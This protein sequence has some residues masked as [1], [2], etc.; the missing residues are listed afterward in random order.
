MALGRGDATEAVMHFQSALA[1]PQN[2]GEAKHLLA[3]QNDI[4]YWL[5]V[6][7]EHQGSASSAQ[8]WWRSAAIHQGDF[9]QMSVRAVSDMTYWSALAEQKLGNESAATALLQQIYQYS[10]DMEAGEP[11]IDYFA[12]SLPTMLLFEEDIRLRSRIE[13]YFLRAQA[14]SGLGKADDAK[15]L[16]VTVLTLDRNHP[17]AADL[18]QKYDQSVPFEATA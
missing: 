12:T 8:K 4:Y 10:L 11:R 13:A 5:G 17:G 6:A 3:S 1:P 15:Q 7:F 2:L 18:L 14:L 16:L 9:Q